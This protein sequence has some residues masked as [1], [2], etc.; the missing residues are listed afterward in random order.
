MPPKPV[1]PKST[2]RPAAAAKKK[3]TTPKGTSSSKQAKRVKIA[4][5]RKDDG[6]GKVL[7]PGKE[8]KEFIKVHRVE[9]QVGSYAMFGR[10]DE[11]RKFVLSSLVLNSYVNAFTDRGKIQVR[12]N[13]VLEYIRDCKEKMESEASPIDVY[14]VQNDDIHACQ[15]MALACAQM[16]RQIEQAASG[17]R[18]F[19]QEQENRAISAFKAL[20]G[21]EV[22]EFD[23]SN[24]SVKS[25]G[26]HTEYG[27]SDLE[28]YSRVFNVLM[29]LNRSLSPT[30]WNTRFGTG[31]WDA[32]VHFVDANL[33]H[34]M[35]ATEATQ[36]TAPVP[37]Q[38]ASASEAPKPDLEVLVYWKTTS[39]LPKQRELMEFLT[40]TGL[41]DNIIT[42]LPIT[43][44]PTTTRAEVRDIIRAR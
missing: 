34:W 23:R 20:T 13:H 40:E 27:E 32:E 33:P 44:K 36:E 5:N 24:V 9:G 43:I 38:V 12:Q 26:P 41:T 35:R 17:Q 18:P 14:P 29:Y 21:K 2:R 25:F 7:T 6:N 42:E 15:R 30:V 37:D 39:R 1:I 3:I 31:N 22:P 28:P 16:R 8:P 4:R 10:R 19:D 11:F